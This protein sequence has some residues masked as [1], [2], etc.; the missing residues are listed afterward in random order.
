MRSSSGSRSGTSAL[1]KHLLT[2]C[3]AFVMLG[4]CTITAGH[5]LGK[6]KTDTQT[7]IKGTITEI[8]PTAGCWLR[9]KSAT[10]ST[11]IELKNAGFVAT[12]LKVGMPI[13]VW[14]SQN[15]KT[16]NLDATGLS[17]K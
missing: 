1:V 11:R 10:G 4:G 16:G 3:V 7:A 17:Y 15:S 2:A 5:L 8:C 13:E 12:D 6:P 14:G 9:I